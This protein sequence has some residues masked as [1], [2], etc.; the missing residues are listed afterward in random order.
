M[1]R[2]VLVPTDGS[3]LS[4]DALEHALTAYPDG[5]VVL[6]HV[7][8]PRY[9][10]YDDD[11]LHPDRIF[12]KLTE[13]VDRRGVESETAVRVGHPKREIVEYS[14][15]DGIDEVVMG[16]HGRDRASRILLGSVAETV[17]RRAPVPVTLVRTHQRT[18]EHHLAVATDGSPQARD[19]LEYALSTFPDAEITVVHAIDPMETHY[20]DGQLVHTEAEY[21]EIEA[22]SEELFDEERAI[23]EE[24]GVEIRTATAVGTD[25][26]VPARTLLEYVD[27]HDVDHVVMGS[28]GRSGVTRV[29]LGSVAETVARRSPAPVTVVR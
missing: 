1:T 27:D 24:Y 21:E 2:G 26:N 16:S 20:G 14:E 18:G 5:D 10:S 12:E 23:A 25:P 19:A 11:E 17:L 8:D 6:L 13:L 4:R 29:L 22:E 15:R 28:H 3:P 7:V 9:T